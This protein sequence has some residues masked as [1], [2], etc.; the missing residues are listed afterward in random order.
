[1][2]ADRP[3]R[4]PDVAACGATRCRRA[5]VPARAGRRVMRRRRAPG[6]QLGASPG[7]LDRRS[8]VSQRSRYRFCAGQ[9]SPICRAGHSDDHAAAFKAFLKS[10][11]RCC[12]AGE[13]GRQQGVGS[14][15]PRR[16]CSRP[17]TTAIRLAG[18]A[19]HQG[20]RARAFFESHFTP[21]R[22]V[23]A[24]APGTAD[25]LLRAGARGLAHAHREVSRRRS[26]SA[27]PIS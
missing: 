24:G 18:K 21:H 19:R 3:A 6:C 16:R 15:Q 13:P 5:Y 12:I 14:R 25:R 1:M 7:G 26:T 4:G 17:A 23:H 27:R 2:P 11:D 9:R 8:A 10:C 22:V 20:G